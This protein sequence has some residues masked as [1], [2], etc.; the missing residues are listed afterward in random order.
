MTDVDLGDEDV[1]GVTIAL[2][3]RARIKGTVRDGQGGGV[4]RGVTVE[5]D[6]VKR[7]KSNIQISMGQVLGS[8]TT[9]GDDG[10]YVKTGLD[11]G[12]YRVRVGGELR[13][14]HA[15]VRRACGTCREDARRMVTVAD[16]ETENLFDLVVDAHDGVICGRVVGPT[17]RPCRTPSCGRCP[18]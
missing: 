4:V 10:R 18:A 6:P 1:T 8:N 17:E 2:T 14:R 12:E 7:D 13:D 5:V 16:G 9:T 3:P 11:A 15:L